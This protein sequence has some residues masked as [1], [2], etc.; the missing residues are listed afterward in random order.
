VAQVSRQIKLLRSA[1][2]TE[3]ATRSQETPAG[4]TGLATQSRKLEV[5][6][7]LL[8]QKVGFQKFWLTQKAGL[9]KI[10]LTWRATKNS[11][12]MENRV[13]HHSGA[14]QETG[15]SKSCY[16]KQKASS[17]VVPKGHYQDTKMQIAK[18]ASNRVGRE[19]R[20][21]RR[22]RLLV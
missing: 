17:T 21:R 11:I 3:T 7:G 19:K 6:V 20:R 12:N 16:S 1:R 22:A 2:V 9:H 14:G 13:M 8:T 10:W 5:Q 15:R 4:L 18:D